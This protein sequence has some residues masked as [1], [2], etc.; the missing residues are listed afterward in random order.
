MM[1]TES[2]SP[3]SR[4]SAV[5]LVILLAAASA[6]ADVDPE[7]E[8][9]GW[10]AVTFDDKAEN[11]YRLGED[12][13]IL[14]VSDRSVSL[15]Q[16]AVSIDVET[17][18]ILVWRWRVDEGV[19]PTDLA[20]KGGDDRSL[21]LYVTFPFRPEEASLFERMKRGM[22]EAVAGEAAPGRIL[23]YVFGGDAERGTFLESPYFGAGGMTIVLRPA[24]AAKGEW[25]EERV[26]LAADYERVFGST[27]DDPT[28]IAISAD[29][30][31]TGSSVRAVIEDISFVPR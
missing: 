2:Q 18:P 12:G 30:D 5:L 28:H 3:I 27:P 1:L 17:T 7:L 20:R 11:D 29:S 16:Q 8:Q 4:A 21:A 25:F 24:T 15:I 23:S 13:A 14:V 10:E 31:D 26:D 9:R 19:P 22:V 6:A